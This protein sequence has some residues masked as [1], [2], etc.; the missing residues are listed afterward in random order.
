MKLDSC[1]GGIEANVAT[2]L[3][4]DEKPLYARRPVRLVGYCHFPAAATGG[5]LRSVHPETTQCFPIILPDVRFPSASTLP[6]WHTAKLRS[7][8]L[9]Q[10]PGMISL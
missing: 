2:L 9:V 3:Y 6:N 1:H 10:L 8:D 5:G 4:G 7:P